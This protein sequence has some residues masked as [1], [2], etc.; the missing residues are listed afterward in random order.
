M[1]ESEDGGGGLRV[2]EGGGRVKLP[3]HRTGNVKGLGVYGMI[4]D[5]LEVC[6]H[7]FKMKAISMNVCFPLAIF[8]CTG[9]IQV[10]QRIGFN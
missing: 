7:T 10:R 4:K 6:G 3:S 8:S 5:P 1:A 2:E 9:V